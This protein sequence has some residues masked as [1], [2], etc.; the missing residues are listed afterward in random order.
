MKKLL[1]KTMLLLFALVAG[2]TTSWAVSNGDVFERISDATSLADGDEVIFVNQ[3]ETHA[4]GT[5][6]NT[7]NRTPVSITVTD[8][9]YTYSSSDNVQVFVVKKNGN[10]FGF[11]TGSGYIYS[12]ST[13]S[14]NLKTNTTAASTAP[15]KTSAWT[16]SSTTSSVFTVKNV[17]N[18]SYY[19][20]FNGTS[21]FSQYKSGQSKPYIYKKR[22]VVAPA[23]TI[24]AQSSN[25]EYGT[26]SLTGT[27]I[28]GTPKSG[29]RYANPAY[30]VTSGTAT[31]SQ[32]GNEFTVTPSSDCTITINFEAIPAHTLSSDVSPAAAGTVTLGSTSVKEGSTTTATAAANAGYK[33]TG[34]SI[35]GT[36]ASLSSPTD[37]PTEVTMGTAEATVTANFEA[38]V[39]HQISW[40]VN[41]VIVKTDNVED[42]AAIDF[43]APASGIPTGYTFMGW[44]ADRI[45]GT[46][47]TDPANYVK[48]ANATAE[49]T[50]YAVMAVGTESPVTA[51]LTADEIASNFA[52]TA[53]AYDDKEKT[54]KD[55]DDGV[56]WG[57]RCIT[58]KGRH[59]MQLKKDANVYIKASAAGAITEVSVTISNVTNKSGGIDDISMHGN[60]AG[61]VYLDNVQT[62]NTGEYGSGLNENIV[63][64]VL[65]IV[66][67]AASN[68]LYIHVD[69]AARIWNVDITYNGASYTGYCTTV[70]PVSVTV[71]S[72]NYATYVSDFDLDFTGK[73]I[74]AYIAKA[75]GTTGVSFTQVE[76]VPANTGVLLYKDGG[77]TEEIPVLSG[78]A[79]DVTGNVFKPGTGAAVASEDGNLHNYILNNVGGVVGFYKAAGKT[80]ATNRAY[81]QIDGSTPV[82][83][84]IALP[85]SDEE[86]GIETMRNGENEK[87]S[88]IF[89]LSGRRVAKPTRGLYIVNGKKVIVK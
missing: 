36:G 62:T 25:D 12:A 32:D 63:S 66:P 82:K 88:A 52:S 1:L 73:G 23:Y 19:L 10:N 68:T 79:E 2:S 29:C 30:T 42:G 40:S 28:T 81:I 64:N 65:T 86:T 26:V 34:W 50:Y 55:T 61:N 56:T 14:N 89:D 77:T 3:A 33:F 74:K 84:F 22:A 13:S 21:F 24:T 67:S 53:M 11:H 75:D 7:N 18:T 80:V 48:A 46:T 54:Y 78:A 72:A 57:T 27:V 58:N 83:G 4:C 44:V 38:V 31:V 6:Q 76:K 8:H 41:G 87:M 35:T 16:L 49:V 47:D 51:Q 17:G 39:T 59:W 20:A 60:F 70:P 85:G 15:T 43:A 71:T 5:T 37:N 69:A 45:D 9:T